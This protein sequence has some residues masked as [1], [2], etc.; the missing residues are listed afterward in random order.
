MTLIASMGKNMTST[1]EGRKTFHSMI[2]RPQTLI[3]WNCEEVI[4]K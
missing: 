1:D 4:P 3:D 2:D